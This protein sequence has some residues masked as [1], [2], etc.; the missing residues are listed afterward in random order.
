MIVVQDSIYACGG[1]GESS[2]GYDKE[3]E[4]TWRFDILA[5]QWQ[6]VVADS[7]L[8]PPH[9]FHHT[10]ALHSNGTVE[11][12]VVFGGLSISSDDGSVL[13]PKSTDDSAIVQYNDVWRL[14]L[15]STSTSLK[16]TM[17]PA[18]NESGAVFPN[19]RSE[20]G[21]VVYGNQ[22]TVFGGIAYDDNVEKAPVNYNDLWSYDLSDCKWAKLTPLDATRPPV[23]FSHSVTLMHDTEGLSYL[24]AFSGRHL[25]YSTWTLLDD[26]WLY[27]IEQNQW[28]P[29]S[30][31]STLARAYIRG[32]DKFSEHV[33]LLGYYKP[34]VG[35]NG[36][37]Y[38][39][40]VMGKF[41]L[42]K[43]S[44][45]TTTKV[46]TDPAMM[47]P[48]ALST[49]SSPVTSASMKVYYGVINSKLASPPLRYNHRA[50]AWRDCMV[51]HGGSYRN[52]RGDIWIYNTTNARLQEESSAALPMDIETLIY[53]LGGFIVSIITILM[54]LLIHWHR[55]D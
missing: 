15:S 29:V 41:S 30:S 9:R 38:D 18:L 23:R 11:E 26:V 5:K 37:V 4:D 47:T 35:T 8:K 22:M 10:G 31:S 20:A 53:V 33:V 7:D 34:R 6:Q 19:P 42:D 3:F 43:R 1:V 55:V 39:D 13:V 36:Y 52:Q 54:I 2:N 25:E 46:N 45:S 16:W 50:A 28:I 17:D 40:F 27:G 32:L 49:T 12:L 51:I 24:L 21:A 48:Q 14:Q 44:D